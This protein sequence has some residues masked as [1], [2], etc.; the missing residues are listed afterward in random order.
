MLPEWIDTRYGQAYQKGFNLTVRFL[1]SRGV[2]RDIADGSGT[3]GLGE[4][5]G[6]A[7][8]AAE[9]KLGGYMGKYDRAERVPPADTKRDPASQVRNYPIKP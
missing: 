5:V 4:R 6:A 8:P 1:L 3:S 7:R 9:R 2:Q